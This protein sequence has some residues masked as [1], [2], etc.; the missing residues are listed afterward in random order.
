MQ[1]QSSSVITN[2]IVLWKSVR[3]SR[4]IV[5]TMTINVVNISFE[6]KNRVFLRYFTDFIVT[7][8]VKTEFNCNLVK[9]MLFWSQ[10]NSKMISKCRNCYRFSLR[11]TS[12]IR[13]MH[14]SET[15][16]FSIKTFGSSRHRRL[17]GEHNSD[18]KSCQDG[19][20][21]THLSRRIQFQQK[22]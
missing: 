15:W 17:A 9:Y 8:I 16:R 21:V 12:D 13:E 18:R 3:Y 14:F 20:E 7:M 2:S 4:E 1:I 10:L 5:M 6:T 22:R 11:Q 19:T